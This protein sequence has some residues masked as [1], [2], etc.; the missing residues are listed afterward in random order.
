MKF[1]EKLYGIAFLMFFIA[2]G[3]DWVGLIFR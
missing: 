1:K 3:V 2:M